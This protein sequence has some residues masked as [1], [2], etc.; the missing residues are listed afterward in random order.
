MRRALHDALIGFMAA[1]A[2]AQAEA[3]KCALPAG[4]E[5]AE[6]VMSDLFPPASR[7]SHTESHHD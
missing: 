6:Q 3:I 5:H 7:A 4:V 1:T 2:Q